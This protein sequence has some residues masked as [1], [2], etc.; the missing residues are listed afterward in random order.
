MTRMR[1]S[2]RI[3][4][5]VRTRHLESV[6]HSNEFSPIIIPAIAAASGI[7]TEASML[8]PRAIIEGQP[9]ALRL[10]IPPLTAGRALPPS[11]SIRGMLP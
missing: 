8:E 2:S 1:G 4:C 5:L 7:S 3:E 6:R 10:P 9:T 11:Q